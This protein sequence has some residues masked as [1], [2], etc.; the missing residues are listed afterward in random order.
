M[1]RKTKL[2]PEVQKNIVDAIKAGAY[3]ET[4]C[5]YAGIAPT[6]AY[7]WIARGKGETKGRPKTPLHAEFADAIRGAEAEV[8]TRMIA[9]WQQ[10]MPGD[11]R[12][13]QMFME[14]RF[15]D[16]WGRRERHEVTGEGGKEIV[17]K[18]V[19]ESDEKKLSATEP[20]PQ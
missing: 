3:F 4:A 10:A 6:T 8:E 9:Q 14:R 20:R 12:A 7:E 16:R 5:R 17:I 11:W 19:Y 15:P 2:T 1:G 18:V 13:I